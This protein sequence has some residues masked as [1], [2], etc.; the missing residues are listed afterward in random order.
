MNEIV[1]QMP[2]VH[3]ANLMVN[4]GNTAY[5]ADVIGVL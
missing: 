5:R 4:S 2:T 3:A 1:T